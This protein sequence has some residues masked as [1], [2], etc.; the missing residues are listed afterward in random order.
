LLA[1]IDKEGILTEEVSLQ[2]T[3]SLEAFNLSWFE[4]KGGL[5]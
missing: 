2:L 1:E 4:K 5:R 3:E